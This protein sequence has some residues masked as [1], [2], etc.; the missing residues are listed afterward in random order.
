M[1]RT[2]HVNGGEHD[3]NPTHDECLVV[4][5]ELADTTALARVVEHRDAQTP[6]IMD[7]PARKGVARRDVLVLLEQSGDDERLNDEPSAKVHAPDLVRRVVPFLV[8]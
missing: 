4:V 5:F 7:V 8:K 2:N 6:L 3:Y 1:I